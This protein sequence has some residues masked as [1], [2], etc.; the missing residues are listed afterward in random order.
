MNVA[1]NTG[2]NILHCESDPL[3]LQSHTCS[4]DSFFLCVFIFVPI[5]RSRCLHVLSNFLLPFMEI[6]EGILTGRCS[7]K[8]KI[9]ISAQYYGRFTSI[10][11][12]HVCIYFFFSCFC[13]SYLNRVLFTLSCVCDVCVQGNIYLYYGTFYSIAGW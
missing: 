11:K 12:R 9:S 6:L 10:G 8:E 5:K 1:G 3:Q 7:S 4:D 2:N 13:S